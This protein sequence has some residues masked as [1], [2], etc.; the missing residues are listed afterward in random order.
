MATELANDITLT[1][2]QLAQFGCLKSW[3]RKDNEDCQFA[4]TS[5][6]DTVALVTAPPG[7]QLILECQPESD[8]MSNKSS[9]GNWESL[10][11]T[12]SL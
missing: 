1:V 11:D 8:R 10:S 6:A 3:L 2:Q 4:L 5:S 12:S 7:D 9:G